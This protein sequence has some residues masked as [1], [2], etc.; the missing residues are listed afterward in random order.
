MN[1]T[2][3]VGVKSTIG[4]DSWLNVPVEFP[5]P[6]PGVNVPD[7]T[8]TILELER[9]WEC[10]VVA[11]DETLTLISTVW[12]PLTVSCWGGAIETSNGKCL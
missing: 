7:D 9:F 4:K 6:P 1:D 10:V 12:P 3:L 5:R 2:C 8:M 11:V